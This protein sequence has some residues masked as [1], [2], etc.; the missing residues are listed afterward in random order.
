MVTFPE[1]DKKFAQIVAQFAFAFWSDQTFK[2]LVHFESISKTEQDR[3][4]NELEVT[5][6]G[7]LDLHLDYTIKY[8]KNQKQKELA[9]HLKKNLVESFV[10]IFKELGVEDEHLNMW[11]LL[12]NMRFDEYR[13]DYKIALKQTQNWQELKSDPKLKP[14]WAIIETCTIDGLSHIRRGKVEE[15][16]PLWRLLRKWLTTIEVTFEKLLLSTDANVKA[17]NN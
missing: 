9:S 3:I 15:G 16:D 6:L 17:A 4:F 5:T 13:K 11:R 10:G 14:I 8:P 12:I 2:N 7:L 1:L